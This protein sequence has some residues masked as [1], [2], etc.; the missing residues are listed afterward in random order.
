M[1]KRPP[2]ISPPIEAGDFLAGRVKKIIGAER[3]G[4]HMEKIKTGRLATKQNQELPT[5][6]QLEKEL[7]D[8]KN[9]NKNAKKKIQD[10]FTL[11]G[12]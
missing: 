1:L 6:E 9:G 11:L 12:K 7:L 5:F 8:K 4:I 3:M 10:W 2:F